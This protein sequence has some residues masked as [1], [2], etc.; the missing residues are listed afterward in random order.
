LNRLHGN[1]GEGRYEN[2]PVYYR[3]N[4]PEQIQQ[5]TYSF[6]SRMVLNFHRVGQLDYY[7]PRSL[8]WLGRRVDRYIQSRG[9]PGS[10]LAVR[11]VK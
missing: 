5:S 7:I 4:T 6:Q 3:C 11:I 8:R 10:I 9:L 2:Y 1:K